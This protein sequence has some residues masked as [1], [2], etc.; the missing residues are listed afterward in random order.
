VLPTLPLLIGEQRREMVLC[1]SLVGYRWRHNAH[2]VR[3]APLR[4]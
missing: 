1:L 3:S 2:D 4:T